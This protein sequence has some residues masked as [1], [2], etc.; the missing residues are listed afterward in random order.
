MAGK[1]VSLDFEAFQF[2]VKVE[3]QRAIKAVP[4]TLEHRLQT[5]SVSNQVTFLF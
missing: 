3:N 2:K 1:T 5:V 4:V